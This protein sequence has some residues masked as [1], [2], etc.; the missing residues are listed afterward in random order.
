MSTKDRSKRPAAGHLEKLDKTYVWHPFTQM[1]DWE[2]D[3]P[4]IIESGKGSILTD[5]R[6]KKYID[7]VSSLWVT[8]HGHRK[9]EIDQAVARQLKKISHSTLLGLSNVPAILLAEKLIALAPRGLSKVFYSDS[10][11]TA[12]EIALKIAFQYWQQKGPEY[13]RK[14]G[15]LSLAGAY[16]GDT[17][18]SVS[19]GG[20][21][22]FHTIYKP[23]LFHTRK[24]ESPHCYRCEYGLTYP[25]CQ[26]TC[27][28][29]AERTIQKYAS[30]TAALIIEPLV[31]GA[32][33]M[34]V[35]PPGYIKR[36]RELCTKNNI[37]M[38]ADE[39]ATGF[40]RTGKMF[41]CEH[42]QVSPDILCLAK[43][44]TGGY[45]PLAA[46]LTTEE[47]YRGFLGE[48][49]EFKTF[50]HGH[51]YTGNPLACA[52][53]IASIDLFKKEKTLVRL[54]PKIAHLKKELARLSELKYVGNIRQKGFMIGIEMVKDRATKMP[55]APVDRIGAKIVMECRKRGLIIRPLG[56]VIVLMPP[57]SISLQELKQMMQIVF[58]S[59]KLVT[60]TS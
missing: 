30:V 5:I 15:F 60:E 32:A 10:G 47:I 23:L 55:Y 46:T 56:D 35:Q 34:L 40:G 22:L 54:Q 13:Q 25:E 31:Q 16:H 59:I 1:K 21:D 7:G 39:V 27:F 26:K 9:K 42:E 53:S 45:L 36:I 38:I 41:A 8:V 58:T 28:M 44:I 29:H 11:S 51:T 37:L 3:A 12:V 50:F 18:G 57:L 52:A 6:G 24:L 4:V 20:I 19:V 48:Y 43:G 2:K 49:E 33:G 17:I 14:T